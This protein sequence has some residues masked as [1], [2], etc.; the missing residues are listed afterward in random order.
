MI[1]VCTFYESRLGRNDGAPLYFTEAMKSEGL[2]VHHL[3]SQFQPKESYDMYL[4]VDWGEDGLG[5]FLPYEPISVEGLAPSVYIASDTHLGF[6]YRLK[7]AKEFTHVFCNQKGAVEEFASYGVKATW[8]PH[9]V[10]PRA[11]TSEVSYTRKYDVCFVGHVGSEKRATQLDTFFREFPNF[12]YGQAFF[13][14][15][16]EIYCRS[17]V[18]I[19]TSVKDDLNMRFF[20]G[21]AT[22]SFV[23]SEYVPSMEDLDIPVPLT[24]ITYTTPEEGVARVH[25]V[26]NS[27]VFRSDT[28]AK[29]QKYIL[30]NHTYSHRLKTILETVGVENG[31]TNCTSI[32]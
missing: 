4:W 17:G 29:M 26:L 22:G 1:K 27:D 25:R 30:E 14:K 6:D 20:E 32:S 19:N 31:K 5:D 8:L 10:E 13:E 11:Y 16:A 24:H 2:N 28:I 9:A 7:K 23:M 12:W 18:V 15:A 21:W 3:S